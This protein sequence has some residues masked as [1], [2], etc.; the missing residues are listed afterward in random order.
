MVLASKKKPQQGKKKTLKEI[1]A[2]TL[3]DVKEAEEKAAKRPVVQVVKTKLDEIE[4]KL[5]EKLNCKYRKSCY[6]TGQKP[7][8]ED[9]WRLPSPIKIFSMESADTVNKQ[10]NYSELEE[11]EKK[12]YCKYRK[13]CYETGVK[14]EIEPEIFIR[15]IADLTTLHEQVETRKLTLQE[16][17]KYRK[18]CYETGIVPEINPKLEAAIQREVSSVIPTNVQDLKM[19][20]KYRKSCYAEIH[21]SA[22]VDTIKII[23]KRRQIEKEV[24]RRKARRAKL[25]RRLRGEMQ[26]GHWRKPSRRAAAGGASRKDVESA[27]LKEAKVE[28]SPEKQEKIEEEDADKEKESVVSETK[29]GKSRRGRQQAPKD[30]VQDANIEEELELAMTEPPEKEMQPKKQRKTRKAKVE[31]SQD[32][33]KPVVKKAAPPAKTGRKPTEDA[34]AKES[35]Q[36]KQTTEIPEREKPTETPKPATTKEQR[37]KKEVKPR[38]KQAEEKEVEK[39]EKNKSED[40]ETAQ[41]VSGTPKKSK[42]FGG[43]K[44][45][46]KKMIDE[47]HHQQGIQETKEYCKYRKSC[48]ASGKR[49]KIEQTVGSPVARFAEHIE[50]MEKVIE[51]E[52]AAIALTAARKKTETDKKLECKYRKSCYETG[53][54]PEIKAPQEAEEQGIVFKAGIS[55]QLQC[56][57]KKSCYK[58]AGII[59]AADEV[60]D[61]EEKRKSSDQRAK[62]ADDR[63][64]SIKDD[65]DTAIKKPTKE[66]RASTEQKK[67]AEIGKSEEECQSGKA[68]Y[69]SADP[70]AMKEDHAGSMARIGLERFRKNGKCSPY[71]YSCREVLGLPKKEKAPIGPNGKRLCRKK[72]KSL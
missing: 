30:I 33:P 55:K 52:E 61:T 28:A 68:C 2:K 71:Y 51:E 27:K 19:L 25:H 7:V 45:A 13:S 17:C 10:I 15:T 42:M 62:T 41:N 24:K 39:E 38:P 59:A 34:T 32:E 8:I 4:E 14:P 67:R 49:P 43:A 44:E 47:M 54:L 21:D 31:E 64:E 12:V 6:E 1:A 37:K 46:M 60:A 23:R 66:E 22:T 35:T 70:K 16:K 26:L 5:Q 40:E 65:E 18:S 63:K 11:L 3:Q 29:K 36:T 48:Y 57:Y 20:C 69:T 50:K 58:E 53:I 9:A 72:P 56:K